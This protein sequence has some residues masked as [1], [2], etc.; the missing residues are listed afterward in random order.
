M[1]DCERN[2]GCA[3]VVSYVRQRCDDKEWAELPMIRAVGQ[4]GNRLFEK[5]GTY[6]VWV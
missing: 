6:N 1:D 4:Q 2:F 5:R 3:L